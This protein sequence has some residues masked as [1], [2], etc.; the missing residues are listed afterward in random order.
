MIRTGYSIPAPVLSYSYLNSYHRHCEMIFFPQGMNLFLCQCGIRPMQEL[1]DLSIAPENLFP[2]ILL[3]FVAVYWVIFIVGLLDFSF[4]D[5][6]LDKDLGVEVD[7]DGSVGA[8]VDGDLGAGVGA[9]VDGDLG[10]SVGGDVDGDADLGKDVSSHGKNISGPGKDVGIGTKILWFLNL[11]DVPFMAFM[12]FFA[13]FFWA[14]CILGHH[15]LSKDSL[16]LSILVTL[17][18]IVI[19][20]LLTKAITQPFRKFFRSL[21]QAE[22]PLVLT[23]Q[24]CT[25]ETGAA[26]DRLGQAYVSLEDKHLLINVKSDSGDRIDKGV[27]CL[28]LAKSD[29]GDYYFIQPFDLE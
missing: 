22:K 14:G 9:Y 27:Q 3:T 24:I 2:T 8:H 29:D 19:A 15:Y 4:L 13:L 26:G 17:G 20:A 28:I 6:D 12:T 11:G 10:A 25:M 5:F 16:L 23:G 7:F 1:F 18:S 21:N